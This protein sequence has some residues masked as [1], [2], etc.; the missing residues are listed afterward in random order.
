MQGWDGFAVYANIKFHSL[1]W[2]AFN[3]VGYFSKGPH[4]AFGCSPNER[5]GNHRCP[6]LPVAPGADC[7][8]RYSIS[9]ESGLLFGLPPGLPLTPFCQGFRFAARPL[10]VLPSV[11][12]ERPVAPKPFRTVLNNF[13]G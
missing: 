13:L 1:T 6:R 4:V 3:P 5:F 8:K 11:L 2:L 12:S 10:T 7:F 9:S